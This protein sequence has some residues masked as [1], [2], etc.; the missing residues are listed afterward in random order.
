MLVLNT[1]VRN[2]VMGATPMQCNMFD[3][4]LLFPHPVFIYSEKNTDP[5]TVKFQPKDTFLR[6][7]L[8]LIGFQ[9]VDPTFK[10]DRRHT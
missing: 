9:S 2:C 1:H 10:L 3:E 7:V 4:C 5:T 8:S 6:S